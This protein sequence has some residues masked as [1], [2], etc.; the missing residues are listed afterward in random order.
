ME[1]ILLLYIHLGPWLSLYASSYKS[2]I[3][4]E[5]ATSPSYACFDQID[6]TFIFYLSIYMTYRYRRT[7]REWKNKLSVASA[8]RWPLFFYTA[9][10]KSSYARVAVVNPPPLPSSSWP[11]TKIRKTYTVYIHTYKTSEYIYILCV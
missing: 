7:A 6:Y 5:D 4:N 8:A 11:A 1:K 10:Y 3:R 2:I 9:R